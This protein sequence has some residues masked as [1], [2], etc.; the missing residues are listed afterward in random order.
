MLIKLLYFKGRERAI[1][2]PVS[3]LGGLNAK[4]CLLVGSVTRQS[5]LFSLVQVRR[6]EWPAYIQYFFWILYIMK[7]HYIH[8]VMS[9]LHYFPIHV[10]VW[11]GSCGSA[12]L[13]YVLM[14]QPL[15]TNLVE[16]I[17]KLHKL[18][19]NTVMGHSF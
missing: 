4:S 16:A 9:S 11:G 7:L 13:V 17:L 19:T 1:C 6:V 18:L 14:E 12:S 5:S 3:P 10:I 2:W 8:Y 15:K